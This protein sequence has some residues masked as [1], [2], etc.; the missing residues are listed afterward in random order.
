MFAFSASIRTVRGTTGLVYYA[1]HTFS[2]FLSHSFYLIFILSVGFPF[3]HALHKHAAPAVPLWFCVGVAAAR[4]CGFF[5]CD[6]DPR[7]NGMNWMQNKIQF[8]FIE[9]IYKL[10]ECTTMGNTLQAIV[11]LQKHTYQKQS[12]ISYHN[13]FVFFG[14]TFIYFFR[15]SCLDRPRHLQYH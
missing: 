11:P 6:C 8:I 7:M 14:C 9:R 10:V 3:R 5:V 2:L 4:V 13:F 12:T 1:K 15:F